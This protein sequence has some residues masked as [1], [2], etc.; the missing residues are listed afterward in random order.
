[1]EKRNP[2]NI[3]HYKKGAAMKSVG[4]VAMAMS[5][6]FFGMSCS[7]KNDTIT[8]AKDLKT[9]V[10]QYSYMIGLDVGNSLKGLDQ[11]IDLAA[12]SAGV[13]GVLKGS[14]PLLSPQAI[15]SI[16]MVFTQEMQKVQMAKAEGSI[17]EGAK[18]LEDNKAK[19]GVITT[20][21]G[22][23]YIV[24]T[25]GKGPKPKA[26]DKVSVH[27]T[28]TLIDGKE[29]DSSVKRGTPAEFPVNGVIPGWSEA[30]QLMNVGSK[31]KLFI[32]SSIGYGASGAGQAIPPNAT[33][34]F[35][36]E[37]LKIM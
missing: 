7:A 28:G 29:F 11:K 14:A 16:K 34:I 22:L 3:Y 27:Y 17:K 15:D 32:P 21:S 20:A 31:Y 6:C 5:L 1:M 24:I 30:L 23:Q 37:L 2:L 10:Q 4:V 9:F 13:D 18:F 12:L 19:P 26:T 8:S 36:V 35:E 33:L 25:E